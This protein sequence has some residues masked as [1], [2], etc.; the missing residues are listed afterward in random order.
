LGKYDHHVLRAQLATLH[1]TLRSATEPIDD[2]SA[3]K[4]ME[5]IIASMAQF[6]NDV[7]SERTVAGMKARLERG[8]WTFPPPLGFIAARDANGRKNLIPDPQRA[9]LI[10]HAFELFSTGL[11]SKQ[12][13]LEKVSASGLTSKSGKHL[14][15]QTFGQLLR[16][17][18]YSG[19]MEVPK[20]GVRCPSNA[21]ALVSREIFDKV[22]ALLDGWQPMVAPRQRNNPDFP[23]RSFVRC[24]RC[25]RPLTAS[26]SKGRNDR[27][28]YYRCQ[29]RTCKA[30]TVATRENGAALC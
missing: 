19:V 10:A 22:Q 14:S 29:N 24:G 21:P 7:R 3:G 13:V 15:P 5:G 20:W 4:L 12:Q 1:V 11:Y 23:L 8:G 27:Y 18:I 16:K 25:E 17:P 26:W 6:D 2:S 9:F 30:V 28:G